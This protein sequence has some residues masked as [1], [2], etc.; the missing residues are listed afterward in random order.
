MNVRWL[1]KH[2]LQT[3]L[4]QRRPGFL[5]W[6]NELMCISV[7]TEFQDDEAPTSRKGWWKQGNNVIICPANINSHRWW[8]LSLSMQIRFSP[9]F[10]EINPHSLSLMQLMHWMLIIRGVLCWNK[11]RSVHLPRGTWRT[12]LDGNQRAKGCKMQLPAMTYWWLSMFPH[13]FNYES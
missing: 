11:A 6:M 13:Q 12:T 4:E 8:K 5:M 2:T 1:L 7:S 9:L 3:Y 10:T